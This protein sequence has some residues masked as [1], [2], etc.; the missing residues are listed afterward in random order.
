MRKGHI[1]VRKCVSCGARRRKQDLMRFVLD[2]GDR[3]VQDQA[4]RRQGRGAYTCRSETCMDGSDNVKKI[5]KALRRLS[6]RGSRR[7]SPASKHI[8]GFNG[9]SQGL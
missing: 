2:E 4:F 1:P 9:K 6:V 7:V 8:G 3:L 5:Q